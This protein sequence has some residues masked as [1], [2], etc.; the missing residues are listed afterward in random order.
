M[1]LFRFGLVGAEKP[2]IV[3]GGGERIDV[4]TFGE[5]FDER[6]FS[7]NG[8]HRLATWIEDNIEKCPV[9]DPSV[10]FGPCI[11]RP[12]KIVCIGI[13][14]ARHASEGGAEVPKEP[15]IFLKAPSAICGPNDD[16]ILP[17]HS[18]KTDWEVELAVIVGEK[19]SYVEPTSAMK[20]VAGYCIH[21][22]YSE[23]SFQFDRGGQWTKGKSCDTFA[24]LGPFLVT[25]DEI[26]DP[27]NLRL[28]LKV[29]GKALQNANTSDLIFG[30]P[31][32]LSYVS[33]F[34]TLV[35]GD[36]ISTG[37]PEGV[38]AGFKPPL[39]L[40]DGDVVEFGVEGLGVAQQRATAYDRRRVGKRGFPT[41]TE[42]STPIEPQ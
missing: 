35:P 20:H 32:I 17:K 42:T 10:R 25:A 38:G 16:L 31:M 12:S 13:N 27:H 11:A 6:F 7:S 33:Q 18:Q 2:G 34:M 29:N 19:A 9:V 23:R 41:R 37:T 39:Y 15:I 26:Q 8:V 28:W 1:K 3:R 14:Y 22:D 36:V 30:I 21:N 24:P 5:D 4:S 40:R